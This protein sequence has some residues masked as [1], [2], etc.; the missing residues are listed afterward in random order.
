MKLSVVNQ[1]GKEGVV[2]LLGSGDFF[3]EGGIAGQHASHEYGNR[4]NTRDCGRNRKR[5]NDS[6]A[7]H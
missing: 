7:P 2:A 4:D 6:V 5:G 1:A 3:G